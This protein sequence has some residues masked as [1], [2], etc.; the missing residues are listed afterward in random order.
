MFINISE[1][2]Y[3]L[4]FSLKT[5]SRVYAELCEKHIQWGAVL[6]VEMSWRGQREWTDNSTVGTKMGSW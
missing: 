6:R 4:G 2:A 3:L 1:T 5:V